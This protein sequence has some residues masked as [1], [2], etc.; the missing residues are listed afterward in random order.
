MFWMIRLK[1]TLLSLIVVLSTLVTPSY[2][3]PALALNAQVNVWLTDT[4]GNARLSQQNS[5]SFAPDAGFNPLTIT[6]D[7]NVQFQQMEGFGA[8]FTDS[9]AWLV[10]YRLNAAGRNTL[11]TNL[12]SPTNGI[13]LNMLRQPIGASD[14]SVSGNYSYNDRPPG[15]TDLNLVN[16]S[17][18][19]DTAYIIPVLQ[20]ALQ[21]NPELK[22]M[23]SPWSPPGWMKTSGSMIGGN[24]YAA[25]YGS[26]ANYFVKYVQAYQAHGIPI[27]YV[28]VQNEPLIAP[29]GYP[30]MEMSASVQA[31]FIK[32]HLGPAFSANGISTKILAYDHNWDTTNY[33]DAILSDSNAAQYISG[34]AW[35]CYGGDVSAQTL[36]HNK[37]PNKG[38]FI[39]ECSGGT[40][41]AND[42]AALQDQVGYLIIKGS[43]NWA[44]S[45]LLWNIALDTNNGPT[46]GGCVTCRG[47]VSINQS[48]GNV[49]YNIDY[50]AL[51]HASKFVR[52]GAYRIQSNTFD[53]NIENVAFKNPDGSKVLI[54]Y[55]AGNA[56]NTFKVVSGTASFSYTLNPGAVATFTWS[57][58]PSEG[59]ETLPRDGWIA[60]ASHSNTGEPPSN[61]L[62][63]NSGTRWSAGRAQANGQWFQVDM[64]SARNFNRIVMDAGGSSGDYPRGYQVYVSNDGTNWGGPVASGTGSSQVINV[65]FSSQVARFIRVVQTVNSGNWWSLHDFN[66]MLGGSQNSIDNIP[67]FVTQQYLD[68]LGREPDQTGFNNWVVTLQGCPEGGYGMSNPTCDRVHVAKSTY[69]SEE[70][71]TRGYWAYRFY[72]VAYGRRPNF[73]EFI[74]DM[75]QVGGTKSPEQVAVSKNQFT[76]DFV[77]R[78]EFATRYNSITNNA[79]YV[80]ALL[81]AAGLPNHPRRNSFIS[82]L[83]TKTRAQVLRDIVESQEVEEKFYVRGF[84]SMM[85]YGFLRRDPDPVGF[86]NYVL[87]LNQTGDA[88]AMTFDFIYSAEYRSR[89]GQP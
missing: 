31:Y 12:F 75:T 58:A 35:H 34:I 63:T 19:H 71:Q 67:F 10:N 80:D 89:F 18:S 22:I 69:Q 17:I 28:T 40:W 29:S 20:Q 7:E 42:R 43:R 9:S 6:V 25:A 45:I 15:Q 21:L 5:L 84:V 27:S 66:V 33:P 13:G 26:L 49:A 53:G 38:N 83:A 64:R 82:S 70:F 50:Y 57:D 23:S 78:S 8:S 61:A 72:E 81:Q 2:A 41:W 4:S 65:N 39:T 79:Q 62:D 74:P 30:G 52:P 73:T 24:L 59:D 14:F 76:N 86:D 85:Y 11:M 87:K 44:K 32:N 77:L 60:T 88:R 56:A 37:Y 55:N 68:F 47:L 51:G 3:P 16:F 54:A 1:V 46:N 48:N 36:F